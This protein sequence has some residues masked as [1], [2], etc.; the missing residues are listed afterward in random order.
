[1]SH[2]QQSYLF[3]IFH[4][5]P[6][7]PQNTEHDCQDSVD[8]GMALCRGNYRR[9]IFLVWRKFKLLFHFCILWQI[10]SLPD[11]TKPVCSILA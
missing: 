4:S 2:L 3:A 8:L 9:N 1:V 6:R 5:T 7:S 11:A 10:T